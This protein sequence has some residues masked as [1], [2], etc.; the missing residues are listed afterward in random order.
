MTIE[1][2][3]KE[4]QQIISTNDEALVNVL[5]EAAVEYQKKVQEEFVI[6]KEWIDE[7]NEVA[8]AIENGNMK[9]YT[10]EESIEKTKQF[11]KTK[12]NVEYHPNI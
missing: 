10:L 11:F 1:E 2:K 3:K 4:L 5:M 9:T 12:Y 6:P 7:A 8:I